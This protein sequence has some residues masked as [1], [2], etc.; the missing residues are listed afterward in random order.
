MK[1][2]LA[3]GGSGNVSYIWKGNK[4]ESVMNIFLA[5][6]S[7]RLYV[8]DEM[9]LHLAGNDG[10]RKERL[11]QENQISILE[12]FFYLEKQEWMFPYIQKGYWDFLLDSGAFT[13]MSDKKNQTGVNWDGY[14]ERYCG[15][16]NKYKVEKFFE[17]DIDT[18]V[19]LK[20]VERLRSK[21][22][23]LTGRQPI[24][25]WHKARGLDYW[26]GMAKDYKYI[27][28]GGIVTREIKLNEHPIFANLIGIAK[29]NG[30][31][32]HGLGYT[33]LKGLEKYKFDSVDSTS[34]LYGNRKGSVFKFNGRT[35]VDIPKPPG[36]RLMSREVALNNFREWVKFQKYAE[37]NL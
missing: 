26:R 14:V 29:E 19:G 32:V 2:Y 17:L 9:K 13:F 22:E 30:A 7:S 23:R 37:R 16:I 28:I 6:T 8:F 24:P 35:I 12:S 31:K 25:V 1:I 36:T 15:F 27:A 11:F 4:P 5:G 21:I 10:Y 33:N 34:W 20:E 18:V 3:G